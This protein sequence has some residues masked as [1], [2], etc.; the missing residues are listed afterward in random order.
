MD[1]KNVCDETFMYDQVK[2]VDVKKSINV[3]IAEIYDLS[4]FY[5]HIASDTAKLDF[6]MDQ[7]QLVIFIFYTTVKFA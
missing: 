4:S 6:L 5:V 3:T 2:L 7:L 1:Y